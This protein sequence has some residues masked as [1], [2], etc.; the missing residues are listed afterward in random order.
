MKTDSTF[1]E[2]IG[3][4]TAAKAGEFLKFESSVFSS[5]VEFLGLNPRSDFRYSDLAQVD[6]SDSNVRGFDFTGADLRGATGVN[7]TWDGT[8]VLKDAITTDS[9]F[10]YRQ[11]RDEFL[12]EHPNLAKRVAI[13]SGE[14]WTRAIIEVANILEAADPNA[15]RIAEAV[16]DNHQDL[17]VRSNILIFMARV[18]PD[19]NAHKDFLHNI[20]A[21]HSNDTKIVRPALRTMNSL[22]GSDVRSLAVQLKFLSHP[23]EDLST[24]ALAGLL[25]SRHFAQ[26]VEK[27]RERAVLSK[28]G[29]LRRK[30]VGRCARIAGAKYAAAAMDV[31]N[32][33]FLDFRQSISERKLFSKATEA[34]LETN[35]HHLGQ[36]EKT[37]LTEYAVE[38]R[39]AEF[40]NELKYLRD[41]FKIPFVFEK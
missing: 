4:E 5:Q 33:I 16:F 23:D 38:L 41:R 21:C 39:A 2:A 34:I 17:T 9:L 37:P 12:S 27:I 25:S 26:I 31:D 28:S 7:V 19:R 20:F 36:D 35:R 15:V 6:F 1:F 10:V 30:F 13:L 3:A 8:T 18:T 24:D 11:R 40:R 14:H 32:K 29:Q 22:Y